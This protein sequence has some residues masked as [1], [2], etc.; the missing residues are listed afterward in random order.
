MILLIFFVALNGLK[1]EQESAPGQIKIM[2]V[3][4]SHTDPGWLKTVEEYYNDQVSLILSNIVKHLWND[5][6]RR[7]T[8]AE[9]CYLKMFWDESHS[10]T[11]EV[12]T[13]LI[14]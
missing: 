10:E 2:L 11:R 12:L 3:L 7:F 6:D 8:W 5:P 13:E 9:T 1:V 4:H 14:K